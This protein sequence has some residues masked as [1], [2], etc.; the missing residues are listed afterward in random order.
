MQ[1][2]KFKFKTKKEI[3]TKIVFRRPFYKDIKAIEY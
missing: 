2:G 1:K 3:K